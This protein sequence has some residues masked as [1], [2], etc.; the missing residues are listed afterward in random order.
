LT[1][2]RMV[3]QMDLG[4]RPVKTNTKTGSVRETFECRKIE[5]ARS[6]TRRVRSKDASFATLSIDDAS[7]V[8][9]EKPR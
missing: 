2:P 6:K 9:R 3:D 1:A 4:R 7:T 5:K 8:P